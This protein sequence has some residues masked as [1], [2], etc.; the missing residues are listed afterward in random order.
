MKK[1][2]KKT[3]NDGE[4]IEYSNEHDNGLSGKTGRN[5][6]KRGTRGDGNRGKDK[7]G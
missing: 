5:R 2:I 6:K 3:N 7:K 1:R 4:W